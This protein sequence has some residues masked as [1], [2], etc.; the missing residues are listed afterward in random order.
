[1]ASPLILLSN[2]DGIQADGL[3]ALAG[4]LGELGELWVV[5]PETQQSATSHGMTLY[6]PL[7]VKSYGEREYSVDGKPADAVLMALYEILPRRPDLVVSGINRGPNVAED[8]LY[9]G[10]VAAATEAAL[11]GI[12][13]IAMSHEAR[14]DNDYWDTAAFGARLAQRVLV[15]GLPPRELLNVNFP[16]V[17][18]GQVKGLKVCSLGERRY[19]QSIVKRLDPHGSPYYW[20]GGDGQ[21][22]CAPRQQSDCVLLGKGY[23]TLSPM[24]LD[25]TAHESLDRLRSWGLET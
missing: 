4:V 20:V 6:T 25:P 5:A 7:R 12:P 14:R 15:E 24:K 17:P 18:R 19:N 3:R 2:D 21:F 16:A 11:V 22:S 10:T 23:A 8:V 9:S 1:M 13:A